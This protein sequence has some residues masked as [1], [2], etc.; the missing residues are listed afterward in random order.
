MSR[1]DFERIES[2]WQALWDD[3]GA[4]RTPRD[5][6]RSR[7]KYYVLDM[8]PYPSGI[9]LHVGHPL[10]Y[11]ATDI[12]ARYKRM[13]GFNVL[14]PI[15]FDAFGLP[16]EQFA[17]EHGVHPRITTERN[18]EN[19]L[20][21]LKRLGLSY[22]W[23]RVLA[24]TDPEYVKWTQWIFLQL[25]H[26]YY[27][28]EGKAARQI[29]T[30]EAELS[31][32]SRWITSDGAL[33]RSRNDDSIDWLGATSTERD[34][35]LSH[36]RL[37][38]LAEVPVNWCP[39][40]GTVLANE[41]VT[42]EGRSERGNFPVFR[43][44]LK[45]WML[46]I[47]AYADR[48]E[49]DLELVKWP[50]AIKT[51]QRNWIGRSVGAR[52]QFALPEF[53][54]VVE[55]FTTR[56]DTL[57][58]ATYMVLA[59]EHPLV[60]RIT[61]PAY[62]DAVNAYRE[63]A[64]QRSE[65]DRIVE[66]REKTGVATGAVALN[67]VNGES[68]PI[69]I[70]DYVLMGYGTGAIM[71]VPA[72]DTRDYAFARQFGLP[73]RP[74]VQPGAGWLAENNL[75]L[76]QYLADASVTDQPFTGVG[77]SINSVGSVSLDGLDTR[78]AKQRTTRHLESTASGRAEVQYKLRDWLFSR[79]RYWGEPF[80]I[81]HGPDGS[82]RPLSEQDL[83]VQ[84]PAMDDFKPT[85]SDDPQAPPQPPLGRA[86][87][88]WKKVQIDGVE[89]VRELNTMPNWAGS[90]WYYLRY[91]DPANGS[92]LV[93]PSLESYWM[94]E[95]GV[96]LYVGGAE[97]AV[98]HLLYAR[99]WHKVL[100]DL[101]HVSGAEPFYKLVNQGMIQAY[102]YR[103]ARGIIVDAAAVTDQSGAAA[104]EVQDQP[105]RQ[106][107]YDGEIV[108][109]EYGKMGKSLKNSVNPDDITA[110]YGCD[111][112]RLYE[113][114]LGPLEQSKPWNTRDII[115]VHRFLR[116]VWRNMIDDD[117]N[118]RVTDGEPGE[119][120]LR[121]LHK[122]IDR[123]TNDFDRMSFNT[124]IAALIEFNSSL[125]GSD[126]ISRVV[127]E[128]LLKLLSPLA[129]HIA[130]ELWS[131]IDSDGSPS[132]SEWPRADPEL[133]K[134]DQ[135]TIAVQVNGKVRA[136]IVVDAAAAKEAVI[137]LARKEE[138]VLRFVEGKTVRREI[139]VP[140]RIVNIVVG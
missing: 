34:N 102:A 106:Y 88:D 36:L 7:P 46:R 90:C 3:A 25:Y 87:D 11:I 12:V 74:V 30:L 58:G 17:V 97:H 50:E 92:Q 109:Q 22:D 33:S 40:L 71:A 135:L 64:A 116:R 37:A 99:F 111:T 35:V 57:F 79:Q 43:R 127:A 52:V 67:P 72:H 68:I 138:N 15:G 45:Q 128:T 84:L 20:G 61:S 49:S 65:L 59:P 8:F 112:L 104:T 51:M 29:A 117:G 123:V 32:R 85:A 2:K 23:D 140:G 48:L 66:V 94:G 70:E 80:P 96:D 6:D 122:T 93:D 9:G 16:A 21:Q 60:D 28:D 130:E 132:T 19:M 53:D 98:L 136:S 101:G 75:S 26:S 129:P 14:H 114:Y 134:D 105:D 131:L 56:P 86:G 10:G 83:P 24:T 13:C 4:F 76:E 41:E 139:Y 120:I 31:S 125:V 100:F 42:N 113:M 110:E 133:L 55:V 91:I 95:H 54:E 18:I 5:V 63:E 137:A 69:W 73:I 124:A 108:L 62:T 27:D 47:T 82:I 107:R 44:P 126:G 77:T 118:V 39:G 1:Y 103:D 89:Y 121:L 119:E 81:L 115:G 78:E 38:Y